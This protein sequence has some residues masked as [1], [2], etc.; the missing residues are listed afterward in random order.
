MER[1][2]SFSKCNKFFIWSCGPSHVTN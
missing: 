2:H 1:Q